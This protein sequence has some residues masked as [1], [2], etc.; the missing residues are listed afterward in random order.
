MRLCSAADVKARK[1]SL[2]NVAA[3]DA[4]IED[5]IDAATP[6][7]EGKLNTF[8]ERDSLTLTYRIDMVENPPTGSMNELLLDRGLVEASPV[9]T[10]KTAFRIEDLD[11]A[12]PL[13]K[14]KDFFV[15]EA[16]GIILLDNFNI[17]RFGEGLT[18]AGGGLLAHS[19]SGLSHG[20]H[21]H[22]E[23]FARITYTAGLAS[24]APPVF[25]AVPVWLNEAA[26]VSTI[27]ILEQ[28]SKVT[29]TEF[30]DQLTPKNQTAWHHLRA[31]LDRRGRFFGS[32][33]KPLF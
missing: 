28:Q 29:K 10:V 24:A 26:V 14:D 9:P 30:G 18:I 6:F 22:H 27:I 13:V 25:D 8:F 11:S 17:L 32:A 33:I 1:K 21:H 19:H 12:T 31:I 20:G 4:T 5:A 7:L 2:P 23:F 16:D 15:K 3:I